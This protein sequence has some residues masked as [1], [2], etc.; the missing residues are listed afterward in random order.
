MSFIQS[1]VNISRPAGADL[2]TKQYTFVKVNSSGQAVSAAAGEA[3]IGVL[4][5]EPT[6][7]Q[8]ATVQVAGIAKVK[9]GGNVTAGARVAADADGK[10]VTATLGRTNTSD[11]GAA[12]DPL[13]GSNV[14]GI[15]LEGGANND[16]IAVLL[17]PVGAAPTTVA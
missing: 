9:A 8:T 6:S 2:S 15:A 11:A 1:Y 3:A 14:M 17:Q 4:Q 5:N 13:I 10:A 16:V 12:A 7:G